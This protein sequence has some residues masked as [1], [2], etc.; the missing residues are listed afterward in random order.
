MCLAQKQGVKRDR[1]RIALFAY[2]YEIA[3]DPLISDSDYDKLAQRVEQ[4]LHV[5]T[6]NG[7]LDFWFFDCFE[8]HTGMWV[9]QHPELDKLRNLYEKVKLHFR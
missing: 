9:H 3:N 2:A 6:G 1:I 7:E 4:N 5:E 8:A